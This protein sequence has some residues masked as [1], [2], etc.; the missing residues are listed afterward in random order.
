MKL[1][2]HSAERLA[3]RTAL[4]LTADPGEALLDAARLYDPQV[5]RWAGR[6]VFSNGVLLFGPIAVTP[7]IEQ[8]AGL[9]AGTAVAWYTGAAE[10]TT[11]Q[12]RSHDAKVDDGELLV[13]GLAERLG[14]TTRPATLQPHLALLASVYSERAPAVEQVIG[15]LQ[16][17]AGALAAEDVTEDSYSLSG[18]KISFYTA[19][20]SPR[21][22]IERE[23]P[24]ALGSAR[25]RRQ[26]HWDLHAGVRASHA[27]PELCRKVGSAGLALSSESG[28]IALDTMGFIINSADDLV[29]RS[30]LPGAEGSGLPL[31]S[32]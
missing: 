9:P 16:P 1:F 14:G 30:R 20:W 25:S 13:R 15:V 19:Y 11:S 17:Y 23:A 12:K 3:D 18:K 26:H 32:R 2:D 5:R 10:Q 6:L 4:L 21:L 28:G 24:A 27:A 31:R 29:A 7:K 22:Y 8:R